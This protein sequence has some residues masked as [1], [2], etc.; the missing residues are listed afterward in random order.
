MQECKPTNAEYRITLSKLLLAKDYTV[1]GDSTKELLCNKTVIHAESPVLT[2]VYRG[3]NRRF[4]CAEPAWILSGSNRLSNIKPYLENYAMYSDDQVFMTGAYGPPV[5][6]QLPYVTR[7]LREDP[8]SRQAVM[9]IWRP[10]P[11]PS[12]DIPCTVA[13]QFL[14][15]DY[16]LHTIVYMR[17]SDAWLGLPYDWFTFACISKVV[18]WS[19]GSMLGNLTVVAGSQHLYAKHESLARTLLVPQDEKTCPRLS[20]IQ[21]QWQE[22]SGNIDSLIEL[23]WSLADDEAS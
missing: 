1:K 14:V 10:R 22:C 15:R 17:S 23:L 7:T 2:T 6:D 3:L 12:V 20:N 19:L 21:A 16:C 4:L 8:S 9:T 13:L 11:A 18:A 5:V